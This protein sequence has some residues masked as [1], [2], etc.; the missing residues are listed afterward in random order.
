MARKVV[1]IGTGGTIASIGKGPL[2][3]IDYGAN[4]TMVHPEDIVTAIPSVRE[5]ADLVVVKFRDIPSTAISFPEWKQLAALCHRLVGEIPDLGGIVIGHGTASL[6]ETAYFLNLT[7]KV[8]V[9]VVIVGSQRPLSGLASDAAM[10]L[11]AAVRAAASPASAGR[12][13]LVVLNDEIQAAREVTKTSTFRLQTFRTPACSA[14]STASTCATIAAPNGATRRTRNSISHRWTPC[15][16]WT[17]PIPTPEQTAPRSAPSRR[18]ARRESSWPPSPPAW[19]R[20]ASKRRSR[21]RSRPALR[22][23]C[24]REP[25]AAWRSTAPGCAPWAC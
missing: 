15:R 23:W 5:V 10:N 16:A 14:A 1:F 13:V 12:G 24:R 20:P 4:N 8:G 3:L 2:D 21:P 7:L 9:P 6:E 17:S 22:S 11:V 25:E 19:S 18:W